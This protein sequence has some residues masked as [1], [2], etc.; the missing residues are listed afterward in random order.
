VTSALRAADAEELS[1]RGPNLT[2]GTVILEQRTAPGDQPAEILSLVRRINVVMASTGTVARNGFLL[3]QVGPSIA[4]FPSGPAEVVIYRTLTSDENV[5]RH[6]STTSTSLSWPKGAGGIWF[7][8]FKTRLREQ[9]PVAWWTS[10]D[11]TPVRVVAGEFERP[12]SERRQVSFHL[13]VS[14]GHPQTPRSRRSNDVRSA[15][16]A[17]YE[18]LGTWLDST[19]QRLEAVTGVARRTYFYWK[20]HADVTPRSTTVAQLWTIHSL[21][22]GVV[23]KLGPTAAREWLRAGAPAPLDY[24]MRGDVAAFQR[25][26]SPVL[27]ADSLPAHEE[28]VAL[29]I[30]ERADDQLEDPEPALRPATRSR[31]AVR[32]VTRP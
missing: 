15:A 21:V 23:R 14:R 6:W 17:A 18:D 8:D 10:H 12:E 19:P 3:V 26:A 7:L 32:V 11:T 25:I 20:R 13:R 24:L 16:I 30:E 31:R 4:I 2:E 22:A 9:H 29:E 28:P 5:D 1:R 27:F